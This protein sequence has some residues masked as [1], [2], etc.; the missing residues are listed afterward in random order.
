[1]ADNSP[2]YLHTCYLT[3]TQQALCNKSPTYRARVADLRKLCNELQEIRRLHSEQEAGKIPGSANSSLKKKRRKSQQ[4]NALQLQQEL[5][6]DAMA[7]GESQVPEQERT[8]HQDL[9]REL[10]DWD[11]E[12]AAL[13]DSLL[14]RP[15]AS[16]TF[17]LSLFAM[18]MKSSHRSSA[19]MMSSNFGTG[20]GGGRCLLGKSSKN[21]SKP[22]GLLTRACLAP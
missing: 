18:L 22:G 4:W 9:F 14:S 10:I 11:H 21:D 13:A 1:M 17:L 15:K 2:S 20:S 16:K 6:A 19:V 3:K 5:E 7:F 12:C 8:A